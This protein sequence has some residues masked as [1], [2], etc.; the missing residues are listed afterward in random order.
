MRLR[1]PAILPQRPEPAAPLDADPSAALEAMLREVWE[2]QMHD[3]PFVNPELR[4]EAIGF[5]RIDGDWVGAVVTPW[6]INLFLLPGGGELWVDTPTGEHRQLMFPAGPLEF[7]AENSPDRA[8]A[9]Q[10]WQYCPLITPVQHIADQASARAA[11]EA[12]LVAVFAPPPVPEPAA[13]PTE[14][15]SAAPQPAEEQPAPSRRGFL[16]SVLGQPKT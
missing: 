13:A 4:V 1:T 2:T 8:V 9:I 14:E 12:V 10:A 15:N 11:A 6:F 3:L 5:R 16:R 7:I